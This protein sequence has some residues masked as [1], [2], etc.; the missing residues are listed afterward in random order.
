MA[1]V[2]GASGRVTA[3]E[4]ET[5]LASQ[6]SRNLSYLPQI[7]VAC[8]DGSS[9]D[10]GLVDAILINAGATAPVATWL[11]NLKPGG[12]LVVPLTVSQSP[13][14]MGSG[15]VL[16]VKRE[17]DGYKARFISPVAIYHCFGSR[18]DESHKRLLALM[19]QGKWKAVQS[20]RRDNHEMTDSCCLHGGAVCLS[21]LASLALD[22]TGD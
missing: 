2:V 16:S 21:A 19:M 18:D 20:L 10:S 6:A 15:M 5:D 22:T 9:Y 7:K 13:G 14:K 17:N 3:V 11:D 8:A 4:I 1:E 12:R